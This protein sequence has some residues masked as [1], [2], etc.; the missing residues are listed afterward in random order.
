MNVPAITQQN[1][2][3]VPAITP[4]VTAQQT[5]DI[6]SNVSKVGWSF[7]LGSLLG[8]AAALAGSASGARTPRSNVGQDSRVYSNEQ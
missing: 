1:G 3:N 4:N 2:A 5:H 6:A 8:L 7:S